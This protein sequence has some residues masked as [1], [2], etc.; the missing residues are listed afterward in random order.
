VNAQRALAVGRR[1][2]GVERE[3]ALY[4]AHGLQHLAGASDRTPA[5]RARMRKRELAW[6]KQAE[7]KGLLK[8]LFSQS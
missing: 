4:I 6:L 2:P 1:G 3:L 8:A 7:K 5:L